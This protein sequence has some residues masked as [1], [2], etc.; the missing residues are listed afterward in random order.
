MTAYA[1]RNIRRALNKK[2]GVRRWVKHSRA[3]WNPGTSLSIGGVSRSITDV[4]KLENV[5][6]GL[7]I[8]GGIIGAL[9]L[10]RFIDRMIPTGITSKL[11]LGISLSN[12]WFSYIAMAGS[13]GLLGYAASAAFGRRYG[14][15]VFWGGIGVTLAKVILDFVPPV[16]SYLG[17]G[18]GAYN[19][20]L[21]RVIEQEVASELRAGGKMASY[22]SPTDLASAKALG[23]YVS[24]EEILRAQA[25]GATDE[26][27][28]SS[29]EF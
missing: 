28:E 20:S 7:A 21:Q 1:R 13:S 8:G 12:G 9:A 18:L 17:V 27:G 4:F 15:K 11:P 24:P 23:D 22:V 14:E 6:D 19:P 26:F 2:H 5:Y 3:K 10:P 16:R 29:D 25:L